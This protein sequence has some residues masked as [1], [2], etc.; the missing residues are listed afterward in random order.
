M[1]KRM[2]VWRFCVK[3]NYYIKDIISKINVEKEEIIIS[4]VQSISFDVF[5][6]YTTHSRSSRT[7]VFCAKAVIKTF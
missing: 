7:E 4:I 3:K 1:L 2:R 6:T 5:K